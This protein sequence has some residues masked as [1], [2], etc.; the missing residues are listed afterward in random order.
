MSQLPVSLQL[1]RYLF[2]LKRPLIMGIV[3][4]TPDSFS[5]GGRYNDADQALAHAECLIAEGA[6]MLDVGGESTRPNAPTVSVQEEIDRVAPV[7]ERLIPLGLPVSIDTRKTSVMAEAIRLGVD[8]V[9]DIGALEAE[10]ALAV[11]AASEVAVCLMHKQGNPDSMQE[12]PRYVDVVQEVGAYLNARMAT[13][14]AAGIAL[15]RIVVDPGFGFGKSVAHNIDLLK[16][17]SVFA[18]L[19]SPLLVGLSR[20]SM[21][22]A[23]TGA[24][25]GER[26]HASV[27]ATLLAVQRGA[28]IVRVHDV[29]A[30]RDALTIL[31]AIEE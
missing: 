27:A 11:V 20:K 24:P 13:A 23:L 7:L 22:G 15:N 25:V 30:T 2:A 18:Q 26:V 21:L 19:G 10:G 28:K 12:E 8:M 17:L 16:H 14:E 5:D 31:N 6:D 4:V 29:K 9:N 1:G 3:N